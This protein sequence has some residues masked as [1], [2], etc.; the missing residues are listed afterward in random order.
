MKNLIDNQGVRGAEVARRLGVPRQTFHRRAKRYSFPRL[1]SGRYDL[2]TAL[3][4]WARSTSGNRHGG[5]RCNSGA[6]PNGASPAAPPCTGHIP[7][8]PEDVRIEALIDEL[9]SGFWRV[10][11]PGRF[12]EKQ[13]GRR[14]DCT[15]ADAR[16]ALAELPLA[17]A[18]M[19]FAW[20][21]GGSWTPLDDDEVAAD[22]GECRRELLR[23]ALGWAVALHR[24]AGPR[25]A[26][27]GSGCAAR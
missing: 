1:P 14:F 25:A 13:P 16:R 17:R 6:K 9:G 10:P 19:H 7:M 27:A 21:T 12:L 23:E 4:W 20:L 22:E 11:W 3:D 8:H 26:V 18:W 15:I 5:L 2:E 24:A